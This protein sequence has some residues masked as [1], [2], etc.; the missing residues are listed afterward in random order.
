MK[1]GPG[2]PGGV[3]LLLLAA[4]LVSVLATSDCRG[5]STGARQADRPHVT[6][7]TA[8][9]LW[10]AL[11]LVALANGYFAQ[12]GLDVEAQYLQGGRYCLDALLSGSAN[13]ANIGEVNVADL[14]YTGNEDVRVIGTIVSSDSSAIIGKRSAGITKPEDIRGKRLALSPGMTSE[15]F[16]YRFLERYGIAPSDVEI[17]RIQP[18]AM[19]GTMIGDGADAASTWEPFIHNIRQSLGENSV[20]FTGPEIFTGYEFLAVR[21][22][23][24]REHPREVEAFLRANRRAASYIKEHPQEAQAIVAQAINLDLPIVTAIWDQFDMLLTLDSAALTN[25]LTREGHGGLGGL[26]ILL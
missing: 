1:R 25:D 26:L 11:S 17:V 9:N 23:W 24:A 12:E 14:G 2:S 6:L 21:N 5:E 15:I 7:A 8:K 16:A 10:N 3:L 4:V 20:V 13:F 19:Q 22:S 18:L